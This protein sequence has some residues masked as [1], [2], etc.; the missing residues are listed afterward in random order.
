MKTTKAFRYLGGHITTSSRSSN[1][2][3]KNRISNAAAM[4]AIIAHLPMSKERKASIVRTNILPAALYG[5][6]SAN[7]PDTCI[8]KIT[9]A[10]MKLRAGTAHNQRD[11]HDIFMTNSNGLDL[12]FVG[13]TLLKIITALRRAVTKQEGA[14][15]MLQETHRGHQI[16][17]TP[18]PSQGHRRQG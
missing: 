14:R 10:I 15:A 16:R 2:T 1:T 9:T 7:I 5:C 18:E 11:L 17:N 4:A 8:T 12:D 3:L 6:E 13:N